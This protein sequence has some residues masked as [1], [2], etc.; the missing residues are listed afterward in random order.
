MP[1][2]AHSQSDH[3]R[4]GFGRNWQRYALLVDEQRIAEAVHSLQVMLACESL[5]GK[6]FLDIGSGSGLFSLAAARLGAHVVSFDYDEQSVACTEALRRKFRPDDRNWAV[7][8]GSVLDADFVASLGKFDVVYSWG[9]LHHTGAMWQ[10]LEH[11]L[12][13]LRPEGLL[14][15]ALYNE[16]GISSSLWKCVKRLYCSS[17]GGRMAIVATCIPV[18]TA[19]AAALD[20]ARGLNPLAR[21]RGYARKNR[22]MSVWHDWLDWLGGYPFE[23]AAPDAIIDF[24]SKKGLTLQQL[25]TTHGWGNNEFVFRRWG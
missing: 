7:R 15:I 9:V 5:Q 3:T 18:L 20:V 13:P 24:Y 16:Q 23:V 12:I 19:A 6:S 21:Y 8:R 25:K 22:G 1:V 10:A 4:F 2:H 11:A 17:R 14:F